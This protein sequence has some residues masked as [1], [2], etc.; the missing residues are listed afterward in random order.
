MCGCADRPV[1]SRRDVVV[2]QSVELLCNTSLTRDIMWTYDSNGGYVDY[3]YWNGQ[4][5]RNKPRLS[6]KFT[7]VD[8]SHSLAI[9]DAEVNESGLYDCYDGK[10]MRKAGYQL[11]VAGMNLC[12]VRQLFRY[13]SK[14]LQTNEK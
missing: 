8:G 9:S 13:L 11:T 4:L 3:I 10:G 14:C 6:V 12:I 2:G 1:Y 7:A 5:D